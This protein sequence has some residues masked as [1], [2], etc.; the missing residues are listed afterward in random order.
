[1]KKSIASILRMWP[2]SAGKAEVFVNELLSSLG[3]RLENVSP[4]G[5]RDG[6]RDLQSHDG[7]L[8]VACYFPIKE[9]KPYSEIAQKFMNDMKKAEKGGAKKFIF[10]TGQI[11]QLSEKQQLKKACSIE[12][13]EIFDCNDILSVVCKPE[14]GFLRAELGFPDKDNSYD[15]EFFNR[16]YDMVSFI[17]L[18]SLFNDSLVPKVFPCD[19]SDIFDALNTFN[20]TAQPSLLSQEFNESYISWMDAFH[21]FYEQVF[22]LDRFSY[23]HANQTFVMKR[24]PPSQFQDVC[25]QVSSAFS[26]SAEETV[27][28]AGVVA[29]KLKIPVR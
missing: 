13:V 2:H 14:S 29:E 7:H 20:C 22:L 25:E 11:L 8:R 21:D 6:G 23:I 27:Q 16:L 17:K 3:Y 18:I 19:F 12:G 9:F 28:L 26:K 1:M 24:I 10:V 15:Y 4:L 5:G